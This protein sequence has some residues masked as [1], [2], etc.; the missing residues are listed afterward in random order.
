MQ[1]SAWG[2]IVV[3]FTASGDGSALYSAWGD[4]VVWF[5]AVKIF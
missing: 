3:W 5:S 2:D 1:C 4:I